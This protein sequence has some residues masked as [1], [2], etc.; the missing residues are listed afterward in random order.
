VRAHKARL[1]H[2]RLR[3]RWTPAHQFRQDIA[4]AFRVPWRWLG[5][6]VEVN[7]SDETRVFVSSILMPL[8][9]WASVAYAS[10][11]EDASAE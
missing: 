4:R 6:T 7:F 9:R 3:R 11:N 5:L 10:Q 8:E 2:Q 1:R